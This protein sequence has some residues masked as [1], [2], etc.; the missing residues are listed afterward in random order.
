MNNPVYWKTNSG[1]V[2][3][4]DDMHPEDAKKVL[5]DIVKR[6]AVKQVKLKPFVIN[7]EERELTETLNQMWLFD[8]K[9]YN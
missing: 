5:K 9:D 3:S 8:N 4:I 2:V 7:T 6:H 1:A